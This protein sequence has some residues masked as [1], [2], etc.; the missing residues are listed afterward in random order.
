MDGST[1]HF[2]SQYLNFKSDS[3]FFL[4]LYRWCLEEPNSRSKTTGGGE[5]GGEERRLKQEEEGGE[6]RPL[7]K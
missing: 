7:R 3:N 1:V 4:L 2:H 6:S 5:E